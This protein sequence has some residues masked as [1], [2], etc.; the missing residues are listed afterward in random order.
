MLLG[1]KAVAWGSV[2]LA[3]D[4]IRRLE[5][6]LEALLD[7]VVGTVFRGHIHPSELA[8]RIIRE[9]DLAARESASGTV[10]PNRYVLAVNPDDLDGPHA[11]LGKELAVMVDELA[12]D[13]G[14]RLEGPSEVVVVASPSAPHGRPRCD[15]QFLA[16]RRNPWARLAGPT[17]VDITVNR[18]VVG[19]GGEADVTV[20][21]EHVS[22]R[23]AM[24]WRQE[25]RVLVSDLGSS[26]G[27][28]VD[29]VR[30]GDRPVEATHH[31]TITFGDVQYRLEI[32]T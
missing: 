7:G 3:M 22:R 29:G 32:D 9:A 31:S 6:R 2:M 14:W 26:N 15:G 17:T 10:V 11:Q 8:E 4:L 1:A 24:I 12:F 25:G 5:R 30:I 20:S 16:G 18:A 21:G 28:A 19:R 13:R 27:T 23:H